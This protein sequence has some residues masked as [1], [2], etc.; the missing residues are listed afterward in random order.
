[1]LTP[2]RQVTKDQGSGQGYG[3]LLLWEGS[4]VKWGRAE[5]VSILAGKPVEPAVEPAVGPVARA[6]D[7]SNVTSPLA[8]AD[9]PIRKPVAKDGVPL[10]GKL[11]NQLLGPWRGPVIA[12]TWRH[13]LPAQTRPSGSRWPKTVVPWRGLLAATGPCRLKALIITAAVLRRK[14][15]RGKNRRVKWTC[16]GVLDPYCNG[17]VQEK[18]PSTPWCRGFLLF[19]D[20]SSLQKKFWKKT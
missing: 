17:L 20:R 19:C 10:A 1:M 4:A 13:L 5:T 7:S 15:R 6:S 11:L 8:G 14:V 2:P 9:A 18:K 12:A 16:P 3:A